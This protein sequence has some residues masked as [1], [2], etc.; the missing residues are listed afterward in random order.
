MKVVV[1][2]TGPILHLQEAAL[3]DLLEKAGEI[4]APAAVEQELKSLLPR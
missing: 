1:C 3:L 4:I 2:D